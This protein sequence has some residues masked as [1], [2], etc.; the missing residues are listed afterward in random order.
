MTNKEKECLDKFYNCLLNNKNTIKEEELNV[1]YDIF[2][3]YQNILSSLNNNI[4]VTQNI[5]ICIM[6]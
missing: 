3:K 4:Q 1:A 5:L 2:Y 6:K